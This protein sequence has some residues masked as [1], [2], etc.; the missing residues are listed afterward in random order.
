MNHELKKLPMFKNLLIFLFLGFSSLISAEEYTYVPGSSLHVITNVQEGYFCIEGVYY[1]YDPN[2][3]PFPIQL[4][5]VFETS[6]HAVEHLPSGGEYRTIALTSPLNGEEKYTF[7]SIIINHAPQSKIINLVEKNRTVEKTT[8]RISN[9]REDWGI[10]SQDVPIW[11]IY[12]QYDA[13]L[14]DQSTYEVNIKVRTFQEA[15][16]PELFAR[17]WIQLGDMITWGE[18]TYP[19]GGR[20]NTDVRHYAFYFS[21]ITRNG[22]GIDFNL[23]YKFPNDHIEIIGFKRHADLF[24]NLWKNQK[25]PSDQ[26]DYV[27]NSLDRGDQ[28]R[29]DAFGCGLTFSVSTEQHNHWGYIPILPGAP[30]QYYGYKYVGDKRV[31]IF[32]SPWHLLESLNP[33]YLTPLDKS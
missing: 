16:V 10:S 30:F 25:G 32:N 8:L 18:E 14:D 6:S 24:K 13:I 7:Q 1:K 20:G 4:G 19:Q 9:I 11:V 31:F 12:T 22:Q 33:F 27:F 2:K 21:N 29:L 5:D 15:K 26:I 23:H 17:E 3:L 28:V